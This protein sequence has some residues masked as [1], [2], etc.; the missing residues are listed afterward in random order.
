MMVYAYKDFNF[1]DLRPIERVQL[2]QCVEQRATAVEL[3]KTL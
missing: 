3:G 2:L 1:T